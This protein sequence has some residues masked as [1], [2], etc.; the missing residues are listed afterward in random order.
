MTSEPDGDIIDAITVG[1]LRVINRIEHGRR[2][3]R[4]YGAG[5]S[6]TRLETEMCGMI[7]LHEGITGSELSDQLGVTRSATSQI[8]SKLKSKGLVNEV[9]TAGD[10]KRKR[11]H[12]TERGL[13]AARI[14]EEYRASMGDALFGSA[15]AAELR[16]FLEFVNRLERFHA[17][18][19]ARWGEEAAP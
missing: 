8:I 18:V 11:L 19:L 2:T 15:S 10:G 7:F 13:R 3:P 14:A 1:L 5:V 4:D 12:L 17:D 9:L 6:M 16:A